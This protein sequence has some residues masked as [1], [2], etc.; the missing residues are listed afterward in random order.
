MEKGKFPDWGW[1]LI[2][3]AAFGYLYEWNISECIKENQEIIYIAIAYWF[4]RGTVEEKISQ[5]VKR[6]CLM[7]KEDINQ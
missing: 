2:V 1:V 6:D 7:I 3:I 4:I 5:N